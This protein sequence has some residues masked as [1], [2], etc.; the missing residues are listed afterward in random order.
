MAANQQREQPKAGQQQK[1]DTFNEC[2]Q[3]QVL[4][5]LGKPRDLLKVQVNPIWDNHYRVNVFVGLDIAS[6]TVAN[7]YFLVIDTEGN[8]IAATPKIA[9]QY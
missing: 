3:Q 5:A 9:K 1:L 8:I 2:I 4:R 6:A 7:S